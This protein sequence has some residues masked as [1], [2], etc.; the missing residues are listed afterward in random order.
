MNKIR[1]RDG[2]LVE[3]DSKKIYEAVYKAAES[4]NLEKEKCESIAE[5]VRKR[6]ATKL[7]EKYEGYKRKYPNV[8][9]IE[10]LIIQLLVNSRETKTA[11]AYIKYREER[12]KQRNLKSRL[13]QSIKE[14]TFADAKDS[15]LK[16]DNGNVNG[17]S[18]MG[19][20]LQ[21][22]STVAKQFADDYLIRKDIAEH[23]KNGDIYI[24]DKDFLS[25]GTLTCC[26]IPLD[27][28]FERGFNT[29]HGYIRPP[30]SIRSYASL[31]AIAIQ[32]NQNDQH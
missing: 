9:E 2:R 14:I 22:G 25:S 15:N 21:Y 24:H 27:K 28:L 20:M 16:R 6:A 3:F 8:E 11:E 30:Q 7:N 1:K 10:D 31:A 18:P 12:T 17:D 13:M 26:Q 4:T 5:S 29:G 19:K 32:A 23:V